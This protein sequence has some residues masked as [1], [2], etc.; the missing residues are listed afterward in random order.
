M[1]FMD[2]VR[3]TQVEKDSAAVF[4]LGQAGFLIKTAEDRQIVIDPYFSDCVERLIPEEGLG[5]KRLMPPPCEAG[6]LDTDVLIISHEHNDHFDVDA[7]GDLIKAKTEVYTNCIVAEA[8]GKMGFDQSRIH[9]MKKGEKIELSEFSILPVDCDHGALAPEALCFIL[10][11]GF[12][13]L[14][15]AGD[16]ALTLSRLQVPVKLQ[17][18]AAILPINGAF[19]N[20][21]GKEAAEYAGL[22]K[23]KICIP[24]HFWTFPLHHGD[25]QEIIEHMGESAPD[26]RLM[27]L[28]QGE[29]FLLKK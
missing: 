18:E 8:L 25:P 4:W 15:Y 22:L 10:D 14:Y 6:E 17:P 13:R 1:K 3:G 20:L 16:T 26:C 2:R 11:F 23:C 7:V 9:V 28:C 5:F 27:L 21:N 12:S 24:C 19:G 29:S